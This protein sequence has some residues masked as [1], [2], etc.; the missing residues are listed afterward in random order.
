MSK[1]CTWIDNTEA[2]KT[3]GSKRNSLMES[4]TTHSGGITNTP[5]QKTS[6]L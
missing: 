4:D 5:S 1:S 6:T 3:V 2:S